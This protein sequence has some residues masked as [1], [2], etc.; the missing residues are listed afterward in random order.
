MS[1]AVEQSRGH[2]G[3]PEHG[4]PFAEGEVGRDNDAGAFVELA[5]QVEQ[6]LPAGLGKGEIAEGVR[7]GYGAASNKKLHCGDHRGENPEQEDR[8]L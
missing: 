6:E 5:D 2:F 3:I 8:R 1:D 7:L 4:R